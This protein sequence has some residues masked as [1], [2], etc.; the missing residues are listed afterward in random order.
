MRN[1]SRESRE[2]REEALRVSRDV[3]WIR[4]GPAN[5]AAVEDAQDPESGGHSIR[6][7]SE[8][9]EIRSSP[10]PTPLPQ[11]PFLGTSA[12]PASYCSMIPPRASRRRCVRAA[13][14]RASC[15]QLK[16]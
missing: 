8:P 6:V 1:S 9:Q 3:S 10:A 7:T 13:G 2:G 16:V 15:L 11:H 12:P 4:V 14:G 5:P